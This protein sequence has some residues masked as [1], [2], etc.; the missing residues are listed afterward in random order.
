[1]PMPPAE[2]SMA[3]L[4]HQL[5][6]FRELRNEGLISEEEWQAKKAGLL[7]QP[8]TPGD[9]RADLEMVRRLAEDQAICDAERDRLRAKLL[10]IEE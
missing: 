8:V 10:G 5:S 9:I 3:A 1:M 6:T 2:G 7:S 4:E